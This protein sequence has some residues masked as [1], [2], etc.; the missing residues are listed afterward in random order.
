MFGF[1]L[2]LLMFLAQFGLIC[3]AFYVPKEQAIWSIIVVI[4]FQLFGPMEKQKKV[5]ITD[6][7]SLLAPD[8]FLEVIK[9]LLLISLFFT[10]IF[11]LM[12]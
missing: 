4:S 5:E 2:A 10:S 7:M 9:A 1:S 6:L 3:W 8:A 12:Q 11:F